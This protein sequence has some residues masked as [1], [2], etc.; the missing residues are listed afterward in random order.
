MM[1]N[2]LAALVALALSAGASTGAAAQ[3]AARWTSEDGVVSVELPDGWAQEPSPNPS[4]KLFVTTDT[5]GFAGC[6][7]TIDARNGRTQ[8]G[9]NALVQ[10]FG[11]VQVAALQGGTY[12]EARSGNVLVASWTGVGE[13]AREISAIAGIGGEAQ[14]TSYLIHCMT[15]PGADENYAQAERFVRSLTINGDVPE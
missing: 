10:R 4:M 14:S 1:R 2:S 6:S 7:V 8:G 11:Q 3:D 12:S 13:R 15:A 5:G 9:V